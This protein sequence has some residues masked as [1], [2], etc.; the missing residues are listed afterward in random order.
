MVEDLLTNNETVQLYLLLGAAKMKLQNFQD[1]LKTFKKGYF[2]C[3]LV[4]ILN[5]CIVF[6]FGFVF[7]F[8][9]FFF[10]LC[11]YFVVCLKLKSHENKTKHNKVKQ[12]KNKIK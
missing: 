2:V 7:C 12:N 8:I 6:V 3:L 9:L 4:F 10:V 5:F 1:A 11:F